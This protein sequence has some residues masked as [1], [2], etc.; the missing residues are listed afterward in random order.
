MT[1]TQVLY[2]NIVSNIVA[3]LI[4]LISW[5]WRNVGRFLFLALFLWAAQ[6]NLR[7]AIRTPSAYLEYARWAVEPYRRFILGPFARHVGVMVGAIAFG[8]AA[9]AVLVAL[10]GRLV[11]L[12]LAGAMVFLLA[13]APLGRGS[14]FPFSLIVAFAALRLTRHRYERTLMGEV[15]LRSRGLRRRPTVGA[16]DAPMSAARG[17][18]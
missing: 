18:R 11:T 4:L 6:T 9:I 8:Q 12:G 10:R 16:H 17:F 13:I 5:R 14:A 1:E 7:V 3:M 2:A 15:A